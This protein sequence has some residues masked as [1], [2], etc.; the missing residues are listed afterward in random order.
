[1]RRLTVLAALL[2]ALSALAVG[3]GCAEAYTAL[4]LKTRRQIVH[5]ADLPAPNHKGMI[6]RAACIEGRLSTVDSRWAMFI[7][8]N[9]KACVRRY[10]GASGGAGLLER[11]STTSVDWEQVGEIGEEDC[12][13]GE[14][15]AS[16]AVLR[17]LG[18][19]SFA[20]E[21]RREPSVLQLL[22]RVGPTIT[23]R[24][25]GRLRLG[26]RA[27]ALLRR[28]LIGNLRKGCEIDVGQ[29]VAP[30][31]SPLRASRRR[32]RSRRPPS[33]NRA[34]DAD[35]QLVPMPGL[36]R[37]LGIRLPRHP[38]ETRKSAGTTDPDL[39]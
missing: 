7:L 22:T 9:T 33:E 2:G 32:E 39:S 29:R 28:H 19:A 26:R 34:S 20:P 3:A 36:R 17:D 21:S 12:S 8:T 15:G 4:S 37:S 25:V 35:P 13:H 31:R 38:D 27:G 5:H 14:D 10:G 24:G 30:L 16:D 11:T 6:R 18:C 23:P 1:M